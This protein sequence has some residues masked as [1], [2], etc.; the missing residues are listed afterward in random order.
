MP[1]ASA[2]SDEAVFERTIIRV[3]RPKEHT[4]IS[5]RGTVPSPE[6]PLGDGREAASWRRTQEV[7]L[8]AATLQ[9][10]RSSSLAERDADKRFA[11]S[12]C[13]R[14]LYNEV[15]M[16]VEQLFTRTLQHLHKAIN[17]SDEYEVLRG[18]ALIRQLFLDGGISVFDQ[19][20]RHYRKKIEF[21]IVD[22]NPPT[23]GGVDFDIWC[24]VDGIDPQVAPLHMP[25][26][27]LKRDDFLT[28]I[29]AIVDG[30]KYSIKD[31][32]KYV[33]NVM[34]GVHSGN[35]KDEREKGLVKLAEL[36][37][38]SNINVALLFV[39]AIGRVVLQAMRPLLYQVAGLDRFENSPGLSVHLVL[40]LFPETD[41]E[42]F[43]L[44]IGKEVRRNRISIFLDSRGELC[45]RF[46][47]PNGTHAIVRA[48]T[49]DCAYRKGEPTYL[50]FQIAL[51]NME[52]LLLIE[53]GG[54]CHHS[55]IRCDTSQFCLQDMPMV[56]GSD[57]LG[58]AE[59]QMA[60]MEQCVYSRAL[61]GHEQEQLRS[62]FMQ[63]IATGYENSIVF[64]GN[65]FLVSPGHPNCQ[66]NENQ[67]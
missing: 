60:I 26:V 49:A 55:V 54:W 32:I 7:G 33:A 25:R 2:A 42:L 63:R 57:V 35:A 11:P 53:A 48:G 67:K 51:C 16:H 27:K 3:P 47:D 22:H 21:E 13:T 34:G 52:M 6:E 4:Y 30:N 65:Q 37:L 15:N 50:N 31:L 23:I 28:Q 8:E 66:S 5:T 20:N 62:Y 39:R 58:K 14:L 18:S 38:F 59:T 56:V 64:E 10:V 43:V 41:K 19:V 40:A 29:I 44:D 9:R 17:S 46:L 1:W 24:V 12:T 61:T 45:L 36:P